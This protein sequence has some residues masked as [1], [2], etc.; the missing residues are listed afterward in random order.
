MEEGVILEWF[1]KEGDS[2]V[3]GDPIVEIE[4]DKSTMEVE[5]DRDGTIL[6][7]LYEEGTTVPVV[8]PIAWIGSPG[9][10]IPESRTTARTEVKDHLPAVSTVAAPADVSAGKVK[11]KKL[12]LFHPAR[13]KQHH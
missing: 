2:V 6:R 13:L 4:T 7:I 9:E 12:T 5:S 8:E 1:V 10:A 3:T 11:A